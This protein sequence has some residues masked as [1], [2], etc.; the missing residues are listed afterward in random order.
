MTMQRT[1][2]PLDRDSGCQF[3]STEQWTSAPCGPGST[4]T[5]SPLCIFGLLWEYLFLCFTLCLTLSNRL[6]CSPCVQRINTQTQME[7]LCALGCTTHC[8]CF[9]L[10]YL[11]VMAKK[12]KAEWG[13]AFERVC[14]TPVGHM[15]I[16]SALLKQRQEKKLWGHS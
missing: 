15:A 9:A 1:A 8:C 3:V 7:R 12:G 16:P 6:L 4:L 11:E 2:L 13:F 10:I 14:M 5:V